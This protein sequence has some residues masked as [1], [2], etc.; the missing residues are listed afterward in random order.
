VS[1]VYVAK[2]K[3]VFGWSGVMHCSWRAAP[4]GAAQAHI[5]AAPR[6][7]TSRLN[8]TWASV[9]LP[10]AGFEISNTTVITGRRTSL[11]QDSRLSADRE[12]RREIAFIL[13][14]CCFLFVFHISISGFDN[15]KT[16]TQFK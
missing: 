11:F 6:G 16:R 2:V 15:R 5:G 8:E 9:W 4:R 14:S 13:L 12:H 10:F 7:V 1:A 3:K